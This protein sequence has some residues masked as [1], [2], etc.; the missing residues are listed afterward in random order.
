MQ[1]GQLLLMKYMKIDNAGEATALSQKLMNE[2]RDPKI[3]SA[4]KT[5]YL[6]PVIEHPDNGS[7]VIAV[8]DETKLAIGN[9]AISEDEAKKL[10]YFPEVEFAPMVPS[11]EDLA[12]AKQK[13]EQAK[14]AVEDIEAAI[15]EK[16]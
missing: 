3:V 16:A 8:P 1:T 12:L 9:A 11:E 10:G 6:F 14:S 13:L 7:A 5:L 4:C 15:K 2:T